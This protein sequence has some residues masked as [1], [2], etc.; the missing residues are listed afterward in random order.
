M[1]AALLRNENLAGMLA[2]RVEDV[3]QELLP[4]GERLDSGHYWCI[5]SIHGEAGQ[6][7]K[8]NLKQLNGH[9]AGY[10]KDFAFD[11]G[12]MC[13][14]LWDLW[15]K[16]RGVDKSEARRQIREFL[17][18]G[19]S[20]SRTAQAQ[21]QPPAKVVSINPAA[22][23]EYCRKPIS[24]ETHRQ[25][26]IRLAK[27]P[28]AMG[29]LTGPK[30][31]LTQ[32]TI[33]HFGLGLSDVYTDKEGINRGKVVT[34]PMRSLSDGIFLNKNY[35]VAVPDYSINPKS[36]NG[37]MPKPVF[38]Y[39]SEGRKDQRI[40][41]VCE[42]LKDVWRMWQEL[43]AH[44]LTDQ[45]MLLSSTHG[46]ANP[47]EWKSS[48]FWESWDKI[49]LGQDNDVPGRGYV[50]TV[51]GYIGKAAYRVEVPTSFGKDWTDFWQNGGTI[52]QFK[53]L[54]TN[55]PLAGE[56]N[57]QKDR[58]DDTKPNVVPQI[59]TF[60]YDPVDI[61]GAYVNGYLYYPIQVRQVV[62]YN[63]AGKPLEK[64]QTFVIRSDRKQ[65]G[66]AYS[67]A[68][69]GTPQSQRVLRLTDGTVIMKEPRPSRWKTWSWDSIMEYKSG[70]A[71]VRPIR[72]IVLEI[73][74]VLKQAV[75]L[76]NQEDYIA[77]ALT[78][79][80]TYVQ[81]VFESVPL[82]LM[83][84]D[85]NTGK[86]ETGKAMNLLC[87]NSAFIGQISAASAA[88]LIDESRGFVVLDDVEKL[89]AKS[90]HDSISDFIQA[91]KV[92]Y[93]KSSATKLW[94]DSKTM[95][96]EELN[97]YG[98]KMLNNTLGT[99]PILMSRM[100]R[101]QTL[102]KPEGMEPHQRQFDAN[103]KCKL[104]ALRNELH[105]W[106]FSNVELV[107]KTYQKVF[108]TKSERH[109][110]IAAPL[111]TIAQLVSDPVVTAQLE[112]CLAR[113]KVQQQQHTADD[114]TQT[115]RE[116]VINL[117][118]DGYERATVTHVTLELR[119]LLD[120]NFG[121]TNKQE[122]PDWAQPIWI[123]RQLRALALVDDVELG[124]DRLWGKNLRLIKFSDHIVHEATHDKD[125]NQI[126]ESRPQKDVKDFCQQCSD[127]P[128]RD[129]ECDMQKKRLKE[130]GRQPLRA[131]KAH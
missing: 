31:G 119:T 61:A 78:V 99:D 2:N 95:K 46:S 38:S 104:R 111:R 18:L 19:D 50:A 29:Y 26:Q 49:F 120:E 11:S 115:L 77:L 127:C 20:Q 67:E 21:L 90:D 122:I 58:Q 62:G 93:N 81:S 55:A 56:V 64:L 72:Q 54:L 96:V 117:I 76:P 101:I 129:T 103:D 86:S 100:I 27:S 52:E 17:G 124:R 24:R 66:Y 13:G 89:A 16:V 15:A 80:V 126:Y 12:E 68:P 113:Q 102:R 39:W 34:A 59:G 43:H 35:F 79:P 82:I 112:V 14:D 109:D 70:K 121:M 40:L 71:K 128:Y 106:A 25:H 65:F 10:W 28:E 97:F 8:V 73:V 36:Q 123:G 84:G 91:I 41:L 42:G 47:D 57:V 108:A 114:P 51:Q 7:L 3:M 83:N 130:K 23:D 4:N 94:T 45:I 92:S 9:E 87:A 22:K 125:G 30:R 105:C 32:P 33:G 6:S 37:W 116:A 74:E 44:G 69:P 107:D 85:K 88:R 63:D 5:G 131:R 110:E 75:W 118:R 1:S 53:E 98:V 60:S 48:E